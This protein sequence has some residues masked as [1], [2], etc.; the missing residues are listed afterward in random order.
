METDTR[1][2][3]SKSDSRREGHLEIVIASSPS[4]CFGNWLLKLVLAPLGVATGAI[5]SITPAQALQVQITP[6][7]PQLGDT[8][9]VVVRQDNPA[10]SSSPRVTLGNQTF[11]T[12]LIGPNRFRALL[13]TTPLNK[14]GTLNI[15][16]AGEGQVKN[17]AVRLRD[18]AFP[19]QRI[20]LPPGKDEDISDAEF[21]RVDAF[22]Q[23]VTPQ[24]FWNGPFLRPNQGEITTIYGIRR[25]YN[26]VFANDY[27]HSGVDYAGT[28]GSPV[29][30]AAAGRVALVGRESQGFKINGNVVGLDHGQGV[31]TIYLHLSRINVKEGDMV[32]AGQ[33]IGAVG[34]SGASTG[35]HLHWGLYVQGKAVD[36]VPWRY[37]G[38]E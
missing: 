30:A 1:D 12:Y 16:V 35:P 28:T 25:Y 6:T 13:P 26:G 15:Q 8:I 27:Y 7:S 5:A 17:L 10:V 24:K 19:T 22:K 20:W 38:L 14:S 29:V 21:N 37:Q 33:V 3:E 2:D 36:P 9:S 31:Q 4:R 18:R 32:R 34:S 23:L 11:D